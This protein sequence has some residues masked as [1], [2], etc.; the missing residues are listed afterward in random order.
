MSPYPAV[1]LRRLRAKEASRRLVRET[2][3]PPSSLILPVFVD[4]A[5]RRPKPMAS[6]P[7]LT[8]YPPEGLLPLVRRAERAHLGGLLLFGRPLRKDAEGSGAWDEDGP[9]P[10]ALRSLRGRTR[11]VLAADVCLCAY[12]TDGHCGYWQDGGVENDRSLP[13]LARVAVSYARAG[14]DWLAPSA[15]LD[16]QV[17]A[18]RQALDRA[19]HPGQAILAYSAKSA[20]AFYDPFRDVEGSA[21]RKGDRRGYQMDYGNPREALREM[22]M[23]V[24]EGADLVMVKP[25][26]PQLDLLRSA[27]DRLSVPLTVFQVS[28]EYAMMKDAARAGHLTEARAVPEVLSAFRRAGADVIIT[29]YALEAVEQG[30]I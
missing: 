25:G 22:A 11:L 28:G 13:A 18:L 9:V 26:L 1:R 24:E 23:D 19:G 20:S 21:P 5:L 27:R 30:W 17:Q 15:M 6:L 12:T 2:S 8:R 4:P 16:G 7:G 10:R 14:A 29:Y 3:V